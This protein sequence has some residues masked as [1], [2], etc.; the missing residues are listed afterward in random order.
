MTK[1]RVLLVYGGK[2][3][4][5]DVSLM[6]ARNVYAA[7][8]ENKYDVT[9]CLIDREG[10]WWLQDIVDDTHSGQPQ[11]LPVLGQ[12]QFVT[13]PDHHIIKPDVVLPVL[14]GQNGEDGTVQGLCQLL[15]LSYVGPS[16]LGAAVTMDKDMT[17]RLLEHAD[18]PVVPWRTWR[19]KDYKPTFD[20]IS[21]ELGTTDMFVKPA[22]AGSSV[23]VSHITSADSWEKVLDMASQHSEVVLIEKTIQ[24]REIEL[25]VIGGDEIRVSG[26]GEIKSGED[27]YDYDDKYSA[28]STA[29]VQ[30]PADISEKMLGQ[31]QAYAKKTFEITEC[32]GMARIDFLVEDE[33][34]YLNEINSIPG[35]TN[36]SMYPKLWQ[37][38]GVRFPQLVDQL[39]ELSLLR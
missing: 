34:I 22:S 12:K 28:A 36:I 20:M 13:L 31:L 19:I 29:K 18:I 1:K 16:L 25:A 15:G 6:S 4:E 3:S 24:G 21:D 39:I 38:E 8:D 32:Q 37:H 2:S 10:R 9:L 30:I 5:H 23:G 35:F 33:T 27:F 7:L 14:H 17:K 11:I 26:A